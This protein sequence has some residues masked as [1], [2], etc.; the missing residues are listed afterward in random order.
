MAQ[1][2]KTVSRGL[3][4]T[5]EKVIKATGLD[6]F[7]DGNDC[8]CDK[9]KEALNKLFP[10]RLKAR[11][12]TESEYNGWKEFTENKKIT[13]TAQE[14]KYVCELYASVFNVPVYY[15]CTN[16]TPKPVILM[17]DRLDLLLKT[18]NS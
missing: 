11:C 2:K 6:A 8:G 17:I 12:F 1:R 14:V 13:I 16:C 5:V 9:R 4:D 3:G 15:P 10:Y 7:V 18:Y